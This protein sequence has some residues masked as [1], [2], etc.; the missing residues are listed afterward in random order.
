L[1][2]HRQVTFAIS[3]TSNTEKVDM[4]TCSRRQMMSSLKWENWSARVQTYKQ[5]PFCA[6]SDSVTEFYHWC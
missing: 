1:G 4:A 6:H 5:L 3:G 2:Q